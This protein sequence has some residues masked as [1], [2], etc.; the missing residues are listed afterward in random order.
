MR[1]LVTGATGF[2]GR[3]LCVA[4]QRG[5]HEVFA[6]A[7]DAERAAKVL[8]GVR[9]FAWNG[10]VGLPP[11]SAFTGVDVVVNLIGES[12]AVRWTEERK[13]SL[14]DSRVLPTR[15]LVERMD[16]LRRR[17]QT[18][19]SMSGSAVYGDR[20]DEI[21][22][23]ASSLG[24]TDGFLVGLS[25]EWEAAARAAEKLGTRVVLLRTGA[26]LG[27]DGGILARIGLPF[28]F[29]LGARLGSGHQ[30]FPWVHLA[31]LIGIIEWAAAHE[32]LS[33]PVNVVAPEPATNGEFTDALARAQGHRARLAVPAFALKL[34]MGDMAGEM[35]LSG[36]RMS[37]V[38]AL[39]S[40]FQFRYPLLA[41]ALAEALGPPP[42]A[43]DDAV[44]GT[45]RALD[46]P[47]GPGVP[48]SPGGPSG[49]PGRPAT[50]ADGGP[51]PN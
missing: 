22:T 14:R 39:Q 33:G 1:F 26:V 36:Q 45:E 46:G 34:A 29:G 10:K 35:L 18:F 32:D 13:R 48:S 11:E 16:G 20:G 8:P 47:D 25:G 42:A 31:D 9:I 19:I 15:A 24:T 7:R 17:P 37:P 44:H 5:G 38:R 3:R 21:L 41:E 6:L 30:Y 43:G 28:R 51:K 49:A 23:E 2:I 4:L 12:V 50:A 40:G 27:R